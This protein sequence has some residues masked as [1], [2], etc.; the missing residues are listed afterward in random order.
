MIR[1]V[2]DFFFPL[3]QRHSCPLTVSGV[4]SEWAG[5]Q[6]D[7]YGAVSGT[8]KTPLTLWLKLS[9]RKIKLHPL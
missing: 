5:V 7:K 8:W 2:Y 3:E 6:V 9:T 1:L 4:G